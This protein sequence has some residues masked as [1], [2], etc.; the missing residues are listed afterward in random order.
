MN[1]F[2]VFLALSLILSFIIMSTKYTKEDCLKSCKFEILDYNCKD[3]CEE[4]W[5]K[6]QD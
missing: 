6:N 4:I 5:K 3:K 2:F 1:L